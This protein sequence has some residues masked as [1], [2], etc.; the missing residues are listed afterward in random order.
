MWLVDQLALSMNSLPKPPEN[1]WPSLDLSH[2]LTL[3]V[4]NMGYADIAADPGG[5]KMG[6]IERIGEDEICLD[7]LPR[8]VI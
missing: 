2:S 4:T 7:L 1:L 5:K 3:T 6:V 8:I